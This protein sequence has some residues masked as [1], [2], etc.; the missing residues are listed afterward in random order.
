[1]RREFVSFPKSG[2]SWIRF[3]LLQLGL[4]V[5]AVRQRGDRPQNP[6]PSPVYFHHD[7]F[8]FIDGSRPAHDYC[9]ESRIEHYN[10]VGRLVYLERDPRDVLVSLYYQVTGRMRD[11]FDYQGTLS[12]FVRDDYFGARVLC[13]Y[14]EMWD[15]IAS[16]ELK[17]R[18]LRVTYEEC[19]ADFGG[20]LSRILDHY[21]FPRRN[22]E[23]ARAVEASRFS[24]MREIELSGKYPDGWL[25]ARQGAPK[26]REGRIGGYKDALSVEDLRYIAEYCRA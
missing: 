18:I 19:H 8:G 6:G 20:V 11:R 21:G 12:D 14:R 4:N 15:R 1:M 2:R 24:S 16:T 9:I 5:Q 17:D 26:V 3:A 22:D 7:G 10:S 25:R 13:G 23:I